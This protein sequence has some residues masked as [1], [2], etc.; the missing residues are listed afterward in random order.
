MPGDAKRRVAIPQVGQTESKKN[1][2]SETEETIIRLISLAAEVKLLKLW[3]TKL[4]SRLISGNTF[5]IERWFGM[6]D[7]ISSEM[8]PT[9]FPQEIIS[10][11]VLA[12][13][14]TRA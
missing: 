9:P 12:A 11:C 7:S 4:I 10:I 13:C 14:T 3:V 6:V 5:P 2:P 8:T 1:Q